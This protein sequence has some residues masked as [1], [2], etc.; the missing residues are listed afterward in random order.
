MSWGTLQAEN[1]RMG[2]SFL[3][4]LFV[5]ACFVVGC[6]LAPEVFA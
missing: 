2:C 4:G 3:I 5:G 6:L 1:E